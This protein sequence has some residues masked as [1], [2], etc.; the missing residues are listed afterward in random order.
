VRAHPQGVAGTAGARAR[1]RRA[2][3]LHR[4]SIGHRQGCCASWAVRSAV[5]TG[6]TPWT[7]A[8]MAR[9]AASCLTMAAIRCG[10]AQRAAA[11]LGAAQAQQY[12]TGF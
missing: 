5:A 8:S 12:V 6:G 10:A 9:S 11:A 1:D 4:R 7:M 2:G 3:P